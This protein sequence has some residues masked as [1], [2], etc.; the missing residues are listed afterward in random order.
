MAAENAEGLLEV[1]W[2]DYRPIGHILTLTVSCKQAYYAT[3]QANE[4]K[5]RKKKYDRVVKRWQKLIHGLRVRERLMKEYSAGG[6]S[7]TA[8]SEV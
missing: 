4:E 3:T 2:P 5:E 7:S 1:R 6:P 8:Q